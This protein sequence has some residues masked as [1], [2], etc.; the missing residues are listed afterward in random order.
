MWQ[1]KRDCEA[2]YCAARSVAATRQLNPA[3]QD[4]SAWLATHVRRI[5][6]PPLASAA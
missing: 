4:F 2:L 5:P 1:F 3:L 6:V